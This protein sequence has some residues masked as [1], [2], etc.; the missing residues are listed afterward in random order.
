[1]NSSVSL[2]LKVLVLSAGLA[3]A[4]KYGA[5]H[6]PFPANPANAI[7]LAIVLLPSLVMAAILVGVK[8][9]G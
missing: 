1:M 4:I 6:L 8:A 7:V 9:E 5:P 3:I 2:V